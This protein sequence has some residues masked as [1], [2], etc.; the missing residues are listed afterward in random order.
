MVEDG[1]RKKFSADI[2]EEFLSF[3]PPAPRFEAG[4]SEKEEE[5]AS[6]EDVPTK[7]KVDGL[8]ERA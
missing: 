4:T 7:D 3:R 1:R 6:R 2:A 5:P 8:G